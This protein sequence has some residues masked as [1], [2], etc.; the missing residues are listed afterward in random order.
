MADI[1]DT[2]TRSR[3]MSGIR[4]GNTKPERV[5]RTLLHAEG[6]RFRL[7]ADLPGKP[8]LVFPRYKA[9]LFVHGCFWHGHD[10]RLFR[11]PATRA[12]FWRTKIGHNRARDTEVLQALASAGWRVGVIW[13]CAMRGA[14]KDLVRLTDEMARWL[15]SNRK[16]LEIKE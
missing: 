11:W 9:A 5:V 8:D 10:C 1:V 3:M 12:E 7:H 4:G 16:R 13:E 14:D 2:A 15:R 6:F